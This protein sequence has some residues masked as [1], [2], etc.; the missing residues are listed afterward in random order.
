MLASVV[1]APPI[2]STNGQRAAVV[3]RT[4][5]CT[6]YWGS[7]GTKRFAASLH[8]RSPLEQ[9]GYRLQLKGRRA[10]KCEEVQPNP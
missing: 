4:I 3:C 7:I 1:G 9:A 8:S 2:R 10:R 5:P 6:A